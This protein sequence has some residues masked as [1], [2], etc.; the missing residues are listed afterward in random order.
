[1]PLDRASSIFSRIRREAGQTALR[2]ARRL[3]KSTYKLEAYKLEGIFG[4][5]TKQLIING[6]Q[7]LYDS[8]HHQ[9][10]LFFAELWKKP[11]NSV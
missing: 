9:S 8:V 10:I 5:H 11:A 3:E 6:C 4:L 7:N 2:L 1:M